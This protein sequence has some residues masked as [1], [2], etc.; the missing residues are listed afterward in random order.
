VTFGTAADT[1]Y[2]TSA[3]NAATTYVGNDHYWVSHRSTTAQHRA[4]EL[5]SWNGSTLTNQQNFLNSSVADGGGDFNA[6]GFVH[7]GSQYRAMVAGYGNNLNGTNHATVK[8]NSSVGSEA[9]LTPATSGWFDGGTYN[10]C[11]AY[12]INLD[13]SS[14]AIH[15]QPS[16]GRNSIKAVAIDATWNSG[17]TAPSNS[18]GSIITL[19]GTDYSPI[20]FGIGSTDDQAYYYYDDGGTLSYRPITASGTTL[21]EG[22]A[23]ATS[24]S[25]STNVGTTRWEC[26]KSGSGDYLVGVVDSTS[27]NVPDIFALKI[28]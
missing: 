13:N 25:L 3:G 1:N 18:L 22:T 24:L 11:D 10:G 17:N 2:T 15:F 19:T 5:W 16:S 27:G 8:F 6:A 14:K 12:A 26:A 7:S 23:V 9:S 4:N 28:S 21:T 20:G